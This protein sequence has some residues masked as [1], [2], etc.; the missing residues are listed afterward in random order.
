MTERTHLRVATSVMAQTASSLASCAARPKKVRGRPPPW[1]AAASRWRPPK[2]SRRDRDPRCSPTVSS[3]RA[4]RWSPASSTPSPTHFSISSPI[5]SCRLWKA[6]GQPQRGRRRRSPRSSWLYQRRR[7][8]LLAGEHPLRMTVALGAVML[9]A[10]R[11]PRSPVAAVVSA[12]ILVSTALRQ[13]RPGGNSAAVWTPTT[14][15]S[16]RGGQS[17]LLPRPRL[18]RCPRCPPLRPALERY[19]CA[20]EGWAPM[21]AAAAAPLSRGQEL[22]VPRLWHGPA[23]RRAAGPV[24]RGRRRR[25]QRLGRLVLPNLWARASG[26]LTWARARLR[27]RVARDA[28]VRGPRERRGSPPLRA[29]LRLLPGVL[30]LS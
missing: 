2:R 18:P 13:R 29:P 8:H 11:P 7:S 17:L 26:S 6:S 20:A 30:P 21:G 28:G 5:C 15:I 24:P 3:A 19:L 23:L 1:P 14:M 16:R 25:A 10:A 4:P 12:P 27:T 9:R 22:A